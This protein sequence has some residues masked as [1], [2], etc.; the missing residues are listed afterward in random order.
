[1]NPARLAKQ[2]P[3]SLD[4]GYLLL[5]SQTPKQPGTLPAI[6]PPPDLGNG[7]HLAYAIQWFLFIP[8]A[9]GVYAALLRREARK[10]VRIT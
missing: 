8:T 10:S 7:P 2:L 3:Y 1:V 5:A 9:L 6:V 4:D